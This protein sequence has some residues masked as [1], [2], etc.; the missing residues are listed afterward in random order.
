MKTPYRMCTPLALAISVLYVT[1]AGC[2]QSGTSQPHDV[3]PYA[4]WRPYC[5]ASH[6]QV[7][8]KFHSGMTT[9]P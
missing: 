2:T 1:L 9:A 5:Y 8:S 3:N 4:C 6:Q 7:T